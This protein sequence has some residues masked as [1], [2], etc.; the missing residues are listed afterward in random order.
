[1]LE[2]DGNVCRARVGKGVPKHVDLRERFVGPE[3]AENSRDAAVADPVVG[4]LEHPQARRL[5]SGII[6][7]VVIIIISFFFFGLFEL[8][9]QQKKD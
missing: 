5:G 6:V 4:E 9:S 7:V 3:A 1:V 8:D 2:T